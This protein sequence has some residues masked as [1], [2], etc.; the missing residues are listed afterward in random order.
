MNWEKSFDEWKKIDY[1]MKIF[2]LQNKD[3]KFKFF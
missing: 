2:R 3:R 1:R